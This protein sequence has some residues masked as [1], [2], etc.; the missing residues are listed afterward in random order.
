M[1]FTDKIKLMQD[2]IEWYYL[3]SSAECHELSSNWNAMI[4]AACFGGGE[5][6]DPYQERNFQAIARKRQIEKHI[7]K[8]PRRYLKILIDT[9]ANLRQDPLLTKHFHRYAGAIKHSQLLPLLEIFILLNK[10]DLTPKKMTEADKI[11]L[12]ALRDRAAMDYDAAVNSYI[13]A[14]KSKLNNK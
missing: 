6:H 12:K 10:H 3:Y 7:R 8:V 5:Y 14:R 9:F 13:I 1:I 2:E 11:L 4:T